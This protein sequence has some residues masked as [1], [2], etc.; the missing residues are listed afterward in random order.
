[1]FVTKDAVAEWGGRVD[2]VLVRAAENHDDYHVALRL[3]EL[4]LQDEPSVQTFPGWVRGYEGFPELV[5]RYVNTF[6][7]AA[8]ETEQIERPLVLTRRIPGVAKTPGGSREGKPPLSYA[9]RP[10]PAC[11]RGSTDRSRG[12]SSS[13]PAQPVARGREADG[14]PLRFVT[15]RFDNDEFLMTFS[16]W[17]FATD[18]MGEDISGKLTP[19]HARRGLTPRRPFA[20]RHPVIA[21]NGLTIDFHVYNGS[22]RECFI[23]SLYL[24]VEERFDVGEEMAWNEWLP[25]LEPPTFEVALTGD[26]DY[27]E[28]TCD[29]RPVYAVGPGAAEHFRLEV[30]GGPGSENCIVRF[31]LGAAAHDAPG[32]RYDVTSDRAFHVAFCPRLNAAVNAGSETD[33]TDAR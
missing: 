30:R 24:F 4:L 5:S 7:K 25:L 31:R 10:A 21:A 27:Y 9:L 12:R 22:D 3:H 8:A 26:T 15:N 2:R 29:R 28:L 13:P 19:Y 18:P 20:S 1:M 23:D 11:C 32:G 33:G 14:G 16:P 17:P 6:L